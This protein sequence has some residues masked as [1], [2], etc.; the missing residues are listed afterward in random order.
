MKGYTDKEIKSLLSAVNAANEKGESLSGAFAAF[1]KKTGRARGSVRNYYYK[2]M[3]DAAENEY[4]AEKYGAL[5]CLK[6]NRNVAFSR[7]EEKRLYEKVTEGVKKG[8]SVRKT[9]YALAGGDEKLALR[10]QN[11]YRNMKK[12]RDEI[13]DSD[14]IYASLTEKINGLVER[15]GLSLRREN[16]KL[17]K[18]IFELKTENEA[19]KRGDNRSAVKEF[20]VNNEDKAE[21]SV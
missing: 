12:L 7:E 15:I 14:D 1:A 8:K 21:K 20:F 18:R 16:E 2:L 19:L 17:K 6:V 10:Y 9:V 4:L 13:T 11:K 3:K 5:P